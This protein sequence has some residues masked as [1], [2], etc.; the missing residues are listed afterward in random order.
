VSGSFLLGEEYGKIC[1]G[2]DVIQI[3]TDRTTALCAESICFPT[4]P[5]RSDAG[6]SGSA[7]SPYLKIFK[8]DRTLTLPL[9]SQVAYPGRD[10]LSTART[11]T[12]PTRTSISDHP[13]SP[14][15]GD[16]TDVINST[17]H[18]AAATPVDKRHGSTFDLV[19]LQWSILLD[20]L[21]TALLTLSSQG[22]H[23][24]AAAVTLPFASGTGAAA[25]GL[26]LDFVGAE[27][28]ADALSGIALIE[29]VGKSRLIPLS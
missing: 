18:D 10:Y 21:L 25:K 26:A 27:E 7:N 19:F 15:Q 9:P 17:H 13:D 11:P 5:K 24:F 1:I 4:R 29:K 12:P 23:M 6:E 20:G 16:P 2:A 28:R 22:W 8:R 3:R 14:T